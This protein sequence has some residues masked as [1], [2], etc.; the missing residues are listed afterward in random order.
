MKRR[1]LV[2]IIL[3]TLCIALIA[4]GFF[5]FR[6]TDYSDAKKLITAIEEDDLA[7]VER[8]VQKNPDC[9]NVLPYRAPMG[10]LAEMNVT[11]AHPLT[12]ACM[13]GNYEIVKLL[14]ESGAD[15]NV[16]S[17]MHTPLSAAYREKP[18]H[19][20]KIAEL[21]IE[22]GADINYATSV[23][24]SILE[25]IVQ[26]RPG[27]AAPGY[28]EED[29]EQVCAAFNYALEHCDHKKTDW[30]A[31]I[32]QCVTNDR[33]EIVR[34]LLDEG[35]CTVNEK[36]KGGDMTPLMFAARDSTPEMVELLLSYGAEQTAKD[37]NGMTAYDYA[38]KFEKTEIVKL[39]EV[40]QGDG[41]AS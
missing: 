21:L 3:S 12:K 14:V 28:I 2:I 8:I 36:R 41:S 10:L 7:A 35:Y 5:L 15:V 31:V 19:W 34:L 22:H 9:I 29:P 32:Q 18:D 13:T 38:T 1:T 20:Y 6:N 17:G 30:G 39:L 16:N 11:V 33:T 24:T 27:G 4:G 23:S 37:K 26:H 25:D 40:G